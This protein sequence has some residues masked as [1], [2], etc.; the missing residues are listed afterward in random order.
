MPVCQLSGWRRHGGLAED[1]VVRHPLGNAA[2]DRRSLPAGLGKTQRPVDR[3]REETGASWARSATRRTA[4]SAYPTHL[5]AWDLVRCLGNS[6]TSV[7]LC[8]EVTVCPSLRRSN[9][10]TR[11]GRHWS[12]GRGRMAHRR[13]WRGGARDP[14]RGGG[15]VEYGDRARGRG[16]ASHGD[17]VPAAVPRGGSAGAGP[18]QARAGPPAADLTREGRRDY[19]RYVAHHPAG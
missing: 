7:T 3:G 15:R 19:R 5:A 1:A 10:Q 2:V 6:L 13:A 11:I 16:G 17:R 12:G 18:G 8:S 14:A 9:S 4:P